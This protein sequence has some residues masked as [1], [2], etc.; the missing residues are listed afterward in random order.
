M[1]DNIIISVNKNLIHNTRGI[2]IL[3]LDSGY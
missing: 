2:L 3:R 1:S